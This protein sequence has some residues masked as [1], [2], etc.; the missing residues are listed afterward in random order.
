MVVAIGRGGLI[1]RGNALPWSFSEDHRH[2]RRVTMGHPIIMG[3]R[4]HESIGMVLPGRRNIVVSA[5]PQQVETCPSLGD[6]IAMARLTNPA[7]LQTEHSRV[8]VVIGGGSGRSRHWRCLL[9]P[10]QD[11]F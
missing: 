10:G 9:R 5:A 7:E 11:W 1:G 4:T 6:A 8:P 3:R 2:F